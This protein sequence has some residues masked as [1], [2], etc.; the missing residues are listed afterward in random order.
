[1]PDRPR[2]RPGAEM[3]DTDTGTVW[4]YGDDRQWHELDVHAERCGSWPLAWNEGGAVSCT[5]PRG[6]RDEWCQHTP[7]SG[8][9]RD[10]ERTPA[11]T[12]AALREGST[13][14]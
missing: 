4:R 6:H 7:G 5:L 11:A 8:W 10:D 9:R 14:A 1:M 12:L 2:V 3:Q 13:D